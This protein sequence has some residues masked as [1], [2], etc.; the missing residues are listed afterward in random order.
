MWPAWQGSGLP[1]LRVLEAIVFFLE[2]GNARKI[3]AA[4]LEKIHR[5]LGN[6]LQGVREQRNPLAQQLQ[7]MKARVDK[8]HRHGNRRI[9]RQHGQW[10]RAALEKR[11]RLVIHS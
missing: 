1:D 8:N 9:E 6:L 3:M 5:S 11:R 4:V 7:G 10:C 2:A